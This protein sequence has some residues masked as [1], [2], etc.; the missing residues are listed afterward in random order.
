M[1][2]KASGVGSRQTKG[3]MEH[4]TEIVLD[5]GVLTTPDLVLQG[6]GEGD[7][8][9]YDA[10]TGKKLLGFPLKTGIVAPP[11]T[12]LVDGVQYITLVTGWGGG[13][14]VWAKYTSQINPGGVYTFALGGKQPPLQFPDQGPAELVDVAFT[15]T[16]DQ[17]NHGSLLFGQY[18]GRCHGGGE[19]PDLSY[20][21]PEI[22]DM[23]PQIVGKGAFISKGMPRFDDRLS[24][25]DMLDLKHFILSKAKNLKAQQAKN[26]TK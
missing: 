1:K 14:G 5:A 20:S 19:I 8:Y 13:M 22:F 18:C 6:T 10:K 11:I 26:R 15:A 17:V 25:Q 3:S 2:W 12:Y 9:F 16:A 21:R 4:K 7:F 24:D 23:F